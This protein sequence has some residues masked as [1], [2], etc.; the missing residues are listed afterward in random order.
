MLTSLALWEMSK[1]VYHENLPVVDS[2]AVAKTRKLLGGE[3]RGD[4]GEPGRL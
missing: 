4:W 2:L 3:E 1:K